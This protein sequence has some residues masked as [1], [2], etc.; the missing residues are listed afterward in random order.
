MAVSGDS[1]I[2]KLRVR[3][4]A[5]FVAEGWFTSVTVRRGCTSRDHG[6][7][8]RAAIETDPQV[9][10]LELGSNDLREIVTGLQT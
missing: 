2:D 4:S 8:Q 5:T 3:M 7:T 10:L 1:P 9:V 6:P